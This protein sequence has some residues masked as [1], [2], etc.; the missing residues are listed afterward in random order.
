MLTRRART[1]LAMFGVSALVAAGCTADGNGEDDPP[2]TEP[3]QTAPSADADSPAPS[4]DGDSEPDGS[5]AD[6]DPAASQPFDDEP[7]GDPPADDEAALEPDA[8]ERVVQLYQTSEER[9]EI[10]DVFPV[11]R[12]V[13]TPDVLQGALDE[14]LAGPTADEEAD[15]YRSFFSDDTAEMLADVRLDDGVARVDFDADLRD[16][17]PNAGTSTGALTLL[18][19]LDG[20]AEQFATVDEAIY[21]LDGDV[22]AF[23]GWL[24]M[25]PPER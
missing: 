9:G 16:A 22:D 12:T 2:A 19:Q 8:E 21:S 18:A 13:P 14:L 4:G 10:D 24:Q 11:E 3:E 1:S 7:A 25:V 6:D 17:L 15:G 23:Y 5:D 20:T